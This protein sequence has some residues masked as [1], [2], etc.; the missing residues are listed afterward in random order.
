MSYPNHLNLVSVLHDEETLPIGLSPVD[1]FTMEFPSKKRFTKC[2]LNGVVYEIRDTGRL[3]IMFGQPVFNVFARGLSL[4]LVD[5]PG[6]P[7]LIRHLIDLKN[8]YSNVGVRSDAEI[9][10]PYTPPSKKDIERWSDYYAQN[11]TLSNFGFRVVDTSL[12][13][14]NILMS[15]AHNPMNEKGGRV[16]VERSVGEADLMIIHDWRI[17]R[18]PH[19]YKGPLCNDI[20]KSILNK[21]LSE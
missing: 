9:K 10:V 5:I 13:D 7:A 20:L 3:S 16:Y 2:K 6:I 15:Y 18:G 21:L 8:T 1:V 12:S 19:V 11:D 4:A 17:K 14:D